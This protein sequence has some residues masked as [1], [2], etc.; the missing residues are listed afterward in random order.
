MGYRFYNPHENKVYVA[1]HAEIFVNRL[2]YTRS[3][4]E[5]HFAKSEWE[6]C[7]YGGTID[8]V[9]RT[10]R[11]VRICLYSMTDI[12]KWELLVYAQVIRIF[13][14]LGIR[15]QVEDYLKTCDVL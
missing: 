9:A 5:S 2:K 12:F 4:W 6:Y 14:W 1:R 8:D 11:Q 10:I 7:V 3:E 13:I 15:E